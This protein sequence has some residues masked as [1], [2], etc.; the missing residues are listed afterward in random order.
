MSFVTIL[1][2]K[3][4]KLLVGRAHY[5]NIIQLLNNKLNE[6]HLENSEQF[7]DEFDAG[8][9]FIDLDSRKILS[10]QSGFGLHNLKKDAQTFFETEFEFVDFYI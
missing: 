8:F 1:I 2:R 3:E 7:M 4:S 6:I 9:I 10:C 5:R